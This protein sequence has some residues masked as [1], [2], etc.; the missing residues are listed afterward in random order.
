MT[1]QKKAISLVKSM[2]LSD[3]FHLNRNQYAI[4]CAYIAV[5]E[6]ILANPHSNPLNTDGY[7]TMDWWMEVKQ[8]IEKL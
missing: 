4:E 5:N 3:R 7:S 8:E 1:P 2:S 6:I